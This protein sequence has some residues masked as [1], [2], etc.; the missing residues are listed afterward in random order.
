MKKTLLLVT[1]FY[2]QAKGRE[3]FREDIELS[4]LLRNRMSVSL[5]LMI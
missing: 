1:N 3:Y 2:Y 5:T 4:E